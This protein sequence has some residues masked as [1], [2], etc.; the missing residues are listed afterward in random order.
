MRTYRVYIPPELPK[1]VP[2][3]LVLVFHGGD[4]DGA[5][6]ERLTRFDDLADREKFL[7]VY[8]DGIGKHWND[9]RAVASFETVRQNVDDVAFVAALLDAMSRD[10]RVDPDRVFAAGFSNGAI[11]ANL[12]GARLAARLAAIASVAGSLAEPLRSEFRPPR[13]VSVLLV[14]GSDD[15]ILPYAGGALSTAHGRV[16]GVEETARLWAAANGCGPDPAKDPPSPTVGECRSVRTR[17][18]G[19]RGRSE[20]VLDTIE[21]GGHT[22]PGAGPQP[23]TAVVVGRACP[24]PD[25]TREIWE[26]FRAHPR[27]GA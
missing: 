23:P 8:P 17:W 15:P 16:L 19:G 12:L 11:F 6:A 18:T 22:W 27:V 26:F 7:V 14:S 4:R 1:D 25:A 9:G 3:A 5:S 24:E 10:F 21:G 2:A 20:V 13:S